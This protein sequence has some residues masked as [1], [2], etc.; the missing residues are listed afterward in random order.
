MSRRNVQG[1]IYLIHFSTPYKHAAHYMGWTEDLESRLADHQAG[2]GARLMAVIKAAGID[3]KLT[4]TWTGDRYR[5]RQLKNQ[6]SSK[7]HCPECGVHPRKDKAMQTTLTGK[8]TPAEAAELQDTLERGYKRA[9]Q[10][11]READPWGGEYEARFQTA[12]ECN[13][14]AA[15]VVNETLENG[16]RRPAEPTADFLARTKAEA[17]AAEAKRAGFHTADQL[18]WAQADAGMP[19]DTIARHQEDITASLLSDAQTADGQAFARE[20]A[21]TAGTYLRDLKELD[22]PGL[23]PGAPHPDPALAAKGWHVCDHGIYTRHPDGQLQAEPE[24]C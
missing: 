22:E 15:D 21:D 5:E 20:Y 16:M 24:A 17:Q 1:T 11:A 8:A 10:A 7:R 18:I 9:Y 12:A 3:W 13:E 4:R 19:A 2:R 6:G 23:T 14:V